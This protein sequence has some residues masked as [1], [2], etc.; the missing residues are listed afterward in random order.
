MVYR[1]S[2]AVYCGTT[3]IQ[4]KNCLDELPYTLEPG[5]VYTV[6]FPIVGFAVSRPLGAR[7]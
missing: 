1:G 2:Y 6:S 5:N 7:R 4:A 3:P